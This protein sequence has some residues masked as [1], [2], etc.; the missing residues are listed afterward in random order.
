MRKHTD[1]FSDST[2]CLKKITSSLQV[3][4]NATS[5]FCKPRPIPH[6]LKSK[7]ETV[8]ENLQNEG[9]IKCISWSEWATPIVPVMKKNAAVRIC[10]DFKVTLNSQ[11]KVE[12][13]LLPK[14]ED[15]FANLAGGKQFSEIDLKDAYLPMTVE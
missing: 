12:Q 3:K 2:G 9:I 13:Y 6:S 14:I 15:T 10:G 5:K 7:A 11:P 8:L 4:E 1:V